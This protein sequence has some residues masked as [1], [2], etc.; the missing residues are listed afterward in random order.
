MN[1]HLKRKVRGHGG[2]LQK[3]VC[4]AVGVRWGRALSSLGGFEVEGKATLTGVCGA[5]MGAAGVEPG[6][7]W[8]ASGPEGRRC[9]DGLNRAGREN[10]R[11]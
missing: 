2:R 4:D 7:G 5:N 6:S 8:A 3:G 9:C 11:I 10:W 1:L